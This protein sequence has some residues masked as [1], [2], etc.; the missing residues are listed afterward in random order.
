MNIKDRDEFRGIWSACPT[1]FTDTMELDLESIDRMV[2][3]HLRLGIKGLFVAGTCGEGPCLPEAQKQQLLSRICERAAGRLI[4]SAQVT[5]NSPARIADNCR[6]AADCGADIA[7]IAP[8]LFC[9]HPSPENI[10][11]HYLESIEKSPLPVGI[12][13]LGGRRPTSPSLEQ[14]KQIYAHEKVLLVKD[15]S[16]DNERMARAVEIRD[17][18]AGLYL[19]NGNEFDTVKYWQAG[20]DGQLLGGGVFNGCLARAIMEAVQSGDL[21]RGQELQERMNRLMYD[22]FGGESITCWLTGQ[23][24]LLVELGVFSTHTSYYKYPL[25]DECAAAIKAAVEREKEWLLP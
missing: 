1:P 2:D 7:V 24:Q 15:S 20:Y 9:Q 11:A 19:L 12:Y 21:S 16:N 10:L 23:K 17:N 14:L 18:R 6:I 5:D 22:I 13:D 3:H 25:T 8:A 4:I